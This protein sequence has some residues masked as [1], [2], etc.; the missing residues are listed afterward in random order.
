[1]VAVGAVWANEVGVMVVVVAITGAKG[2]DEGPREDI[3][4][5]GC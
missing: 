4:A 3:V 5:G 1:M 2:D